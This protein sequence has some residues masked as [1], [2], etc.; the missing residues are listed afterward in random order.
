MKVNQNDNNDDEQHE[1]PMKLQNSNV[2]A[3]LDGKLGHLSDNVQCDLKRLIHE[4]EDIFSDVL[5][6]TNAADH[7]V[8][9]GDHEITDHNPLT[10]IHRM[11]N[12]NHILVRWS[13]I[14]QDQDIKHKQRTFS[15]WTLLSPYFLTF[16]MF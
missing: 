8:D 10:F 11:K 15:K 7:D 9:V 14:R 1:Y 5:G 4:R 3:N 16:S 2:L 12:K 13:L 6:R